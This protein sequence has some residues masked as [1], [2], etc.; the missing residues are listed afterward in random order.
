[1]KKEMKKKMMVSDHLNANEM[2][3]HLLL[4]ED[5]TN[6]RSTR[7][8]DA[9]SSNNFNTRATGETETYDPRLRRS[10]KDRTSL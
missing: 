3:G 1:M 10:S 6:A 7:Q 5:E 2:G 4:Q 8:E 9:L